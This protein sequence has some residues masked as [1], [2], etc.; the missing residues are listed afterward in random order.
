MDLTGSIDK[1]GKTYYVLDVDQTARQFPGEYSSIRNN[2][3]FLA[4]EHNFSEDSHLEL[5]AEYFMQIQHA[6]QSA[7]PIVSQAVAAIPATA[8][9]VGNSATTSLLGYDKAL[10]AVNPY[11]PNSELNRGSST[12]SGTYDNQL[13]D[14]FS[15]RSG[16][17]Y[18]R[19]RRWDY[20]QN[21]GWGAV[22]IPLPTAA[23]Q[24]ISST[25]GSLPSRGEIM[26]DGGGF[27]ED[28]VAHY[29]LLNHT[30]ENKTLLTVDFNDYYRWDPTWEYAV[31]GNPD[32]VAWSAAT[33]GRV[34]NLV[35]GTYRGQDALVIAS[36]P[37][38]YF[39]Y[40]YNPA[41]LVIFAPGG[42]AITG[43]PALNGGTL[44]RR[45]TSSLGGNL[46]E[47]AMFFDNRLIFYA[48]LRTDNVLFSER[49]YTV[50]FAS[51]G[52][53]N[54][55]PGTGGAN[56]PGGSVV[57]R[58][59]H[60]NKPNTGFSYNLLPKAAGDELR[61]Y[62]S[63]STA[64]FVDQTS[65]PAVIASATYAPF[66]AKGYDYGIK[67][68]FFDG[69]LA[70]TLG[71]YYDKE[72]NVLTTDVIEYP[73]GSG[74]FTDVQEQDGFELVR[75]WETDLS[76]VITPDLSLVESFGEVNAKYTYFGSEYLEVIGRSVSGV[77]PENGSVSLRYAPVSGTLKG[78]TFNAL[79]TYVSSTPNAAPNTGD[80][81]TTIN[82]VSVIT[83]QTYGWKLRLPSFTLWNF[84]VQYKIPYGRKWNQT[85]SVNL[86]NAFNKYYLKTSALLGDSRGVIFGYSLTHS[87]Y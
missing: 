27:Q 63:Y 52:I 38:T 32:L 20:N 70:F 75:G 78:F 49:D 2:E 14:I 3:D 21:T 80:T 64:Y 31:N 58:Y 57:R 46:R 40:R 12:F 54:L 16:E 72:S 19:A 65:R 51:V 67:G 5:S 45:R 34:V 66:T 79:T 43:G 22:T 15:I 24:T 11:G 1:A 6:P 4:I 60:Q 87:G 56:Q 83:G 10:A 28:L 39:P 47:Q 81:A 48:G 62:G 85:L 69:H 74:Q 61:V 44:T 36:P 30:M 13:N 8:T 50:A 82:G 84:G 71:G 42:N 29:W 59:E 77:S 25:R 17:Y 86:N 33:S 41:N 7:P 76:Y 53:E 26:E 18:F 35:P 9:S 55:A 23:V 73:A 68:T 37:P